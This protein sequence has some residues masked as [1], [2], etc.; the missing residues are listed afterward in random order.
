MSLTHFDFER[1][2][3]NMIEQQVR[4]WEVL[5]PSVLARLGEVRREDFVPETLRALAFTDMELP[6]KIHGTDTGEVMLAPKIEARFLQALELKGEDMVL[7]VGAGSGFMAAL[8]SGRCREVIT[9]EIKESLFAFAQ[10]NLA[11]AGIENVLVE[12]GDGLRGQLKTAAPDRFDAIVL[13][14]A[15]RQVPQT[16]LSQLRVGGRL[17]GIVGTAPLMQAQL[18]TRITNDA[19]D[20]VSLFETVTRPLVDAQAPSAFKF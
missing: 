18:I 13:S 9:V 16:M 1:A 17:I 4:P 6:L 19:Y 8:L 7:E 2:R 5:D 20:T 14:G 12:H 10:A 11:R 3:H 15:V